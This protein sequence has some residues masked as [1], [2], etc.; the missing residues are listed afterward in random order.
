MIFNNYS[1]PFQKASFI[2]W[3]PCLAERTQSNDF[4]YNYIYKLILLYSILNFLLPQNGFLILKHY[5]LKIILV[6]SL[7]T[8]LKYIYINKKCDSN[9]KTNHK[10]IDINNTGFPPFNS[11]IIQA[12]FKNFFK[13]PKKPFQGLSHILRIQPIEINKIGQ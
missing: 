4:I 5:F 8:K 7:I 10:P 11:K 6:D 13:N 9:I 2:T 3:V 1:K 12:I